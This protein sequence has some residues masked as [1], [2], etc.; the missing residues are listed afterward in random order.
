VTVSGAAAWVLYDQEFAATKSVSGNGTA[1]LP[2]RGN[3]AYLLLFG[4]ADAE[5]RVTV[6]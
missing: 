4:A 6:A 3:A 2:G 5:L 1:A